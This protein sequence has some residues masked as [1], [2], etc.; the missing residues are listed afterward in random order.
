VE[1]V[2]CY[3]SVVASNTFAVSGDGDYFSCV[4]ADLCNVLVSG[5]LF[6]GAFS[7]DVPDSPGG[8]IAVIGNTAFDVKSANAY[9][10]TGVKRLLGVDGN[11][12]NTGANAWNE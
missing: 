2:G 3:G 7:V 11:E 9:E 12:T 8:I 1:L 5:N 10:S 4:A 6:C